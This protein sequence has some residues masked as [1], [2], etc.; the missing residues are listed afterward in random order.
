[1]TLAK[2]SESSPRSPLQT[3]IDNANS[4]A[5]YRLAGEGA[6]LSERNAFGDPVFFDAVEAV[7]FSTDETNRARR[8]TVLQT[9]ID[10]GADPNVLGCDGSSVLILPIFGMRVDLVEFLLAAGV[11]PNLGCGEPSE[12]VYDVS[13][14]DYYYEAFLAPNLAELVPPKDIGDE[15]AF[16][17]WLDQEAEAKGYLRPTIP[18]LLRR[19]GALS[20]S[21]QAM[22]LGGSRDD[23]I[24]WTDEGWKLAC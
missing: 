8:M 13:I 3:A 12:T 7:E 1:M 6:N 5:F 11:D 2:N 19:F 22:Q 15:D 21:E 14:F 9:L 17:A 20:Q 24:R 18:L 10:L 4:D 23:T 16:L